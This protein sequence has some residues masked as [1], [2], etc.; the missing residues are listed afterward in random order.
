LVF[1][2]HQEKEVKTGNVRQRVQKFVCEVF[3]AM[4][5][6]LNKVDC[7][8]MKHWVLMNVFKGSQ[9]NGNQ[10]NMDAS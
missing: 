2:K 8:K 10:E 5:P 6:N 7:H 3:L 4:I 1:Q 9:E